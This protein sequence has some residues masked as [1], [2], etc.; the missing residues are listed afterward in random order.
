MA[1]KYSSREPTG[2]QI[3]LGDVGG[4]VISWP[5]QV[6]IEQDGDGWSVREVFTDPDYPDLR[7]HF[8]SDRD[9]AEDVCHEIGVSLEE[10][11]AALESVDPKLAAALHENLSTLL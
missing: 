5:R 4:S 9:G 6:Y 1:K 7:S 11:V 8:F 2:T 3:P 10:L